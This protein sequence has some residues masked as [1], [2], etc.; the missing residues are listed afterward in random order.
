[1]TVTNDSNLQKPL[2]NYPS[3]IKA[4][5]FYRLESH[6]SKWMNSVLNLLY[7]TIVH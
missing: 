5:D 2:F 1:M 7:L 3:F 4:L 6:I